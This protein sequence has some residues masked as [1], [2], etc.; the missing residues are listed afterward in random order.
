MLRCLFEIGFEILI[1]GL[2][3]CEVGFGRVEFLVDIL[4]VFCVGVKCG[5]AVLDVLVDA[6]S[7]IA[8]AKDKDEENCYSAD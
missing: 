6:V 1:L 7:Q 3:K 5:V 2:V 8:W 4:D